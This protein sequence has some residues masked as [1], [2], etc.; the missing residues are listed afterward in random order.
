METLLPID[1]KWCQVVERGEKGIFFFLFLQ[2]CF[3][4]TQK[5]SF[6]LMS[7]IYRSG[8]LSLLN[9]ALKQSILDHSSIKGL[10]FWCGV[11]ME[12]NHRS[13]NP[14]WSKYSKSPGVSHELKIPPN[15]DTMKAYGSY[16]L[17]ET[18]TSTPCFHVS[19]TGP[20]FILGLTGLPRTN[21]TATPGRR[22]QWV[23]CVS[24]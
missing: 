18:A 12:R 4:F 10:M 5:V 7:R 2:Q 22:L 23:F 1:E 11:G 3:S 16:V 17:L 21:M 24:C 13:R 8:T 15:A 9:G 20:A 19:K 6:F 14:I